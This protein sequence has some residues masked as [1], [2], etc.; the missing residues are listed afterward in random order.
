M[1]FY[2]MPLAFQTPAAVVES[3]S[4]KARPASVSRLLR[5]I[6]E[7]EAAAH[8]ATD[9]PYAVTMRVMVRFSR[10]A[11]R[12]AE[13]VKIVKGG[14]G[15][16]AIALTEE[17]IRERFPW[18]YQE[19]TTRLRQRYSDF[20]ANQDYHNIRKPLEDDPTFCHERHLNPD[21][22]DG[23]LKRFYSP[24]ILAKFDDYYQKD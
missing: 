6:A 3:L 17:D 19:L 22:P 7:Q 8:S 21:N 12:D 4:S 20:K 1:N 9:D 23:G 18:S 10:T 11:D 24:N 14:D 13:I 16:L 5:H 15:V 2:L